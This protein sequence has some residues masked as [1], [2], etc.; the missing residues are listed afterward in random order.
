[1]KE[2]D[3][4]FRARWKAGPGWR[5]LGYRLLDVLLPP[6]SLESPAEETASIGLS[7]ATWSKITFLD[8]PVCD[9]CGSPFEHAMGERALCAVCEARRP[10]FARARAA[11]IY[12]DHSRGLILQLKH[13]DRTDL[14]PLFAR[15]LARAAA[16]LIDEA[17]AIVPVPLHPWRLLH[18]RYNQAAEIARPLAALSGLPYLADALVRRRDTE[19]QAGRSGVG[20]QR[21]VAAAF[22]VPAGRERLV[23]NKTV[24]LVDDVLTTGA[25]AAGCARALLKAGAVSVSVAVVAR[26][27]SRSVV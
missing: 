23:Q 4:P 7:A 20:R 19:S 5:R 21:N 27:N 12:D 14:A 26:V 15:W 2:Q 24:L 18:R 16:P 8:D 6:A 25:T 13:A 17:H 1:M 3:E 11:C 9:G 10:S 22:A